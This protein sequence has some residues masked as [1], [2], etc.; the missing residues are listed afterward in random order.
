MIKPRRNGLLFTGFSLTTAH[1]LTIIN[2][3]VAAKTAY[4]AKD[5]TN[6]AE[7]QYFVTEEGLAA[8]EE[9]LKYLKTVRRKE[10]AEKIKVALSF[11]DLSEN[12][13]YDEAKNDQAIMEARIADLEVMLKNAVVIDESELNNETVHIGSKIEVNITMPDGKKSERDYKIV[14]SNEADPR[15]GKISDESAV[16]KALL[17]AKVGQT[18]KVEI[19]AGIAKYKIVTISR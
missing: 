2:D 6:M 8:L 18:V 3:N 14:G 13:E 10:V 7:K 4:F 15:N 1:N 11:G 5:G 17:G 16:G 19:P 12:S 9:E